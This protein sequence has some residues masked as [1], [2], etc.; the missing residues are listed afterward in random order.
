MDVWNKGQINGHRQAAARLETI[1]NAAFDFIRTRPDTTEYE[2]QQ[3]VKAEFRKHGLGRDRFYPNPIV[4][5]GPSSD[6]PHYMPSAKSSRRSRPNTLVM[7]DIWGHLPGMPFADITWMAFCGKK[8]PAEMKK[9]FDLVLRSR[10]AAIAHIKKELRAGRMP[11]GSETDR[12][13][14]DV[15]RKAGYGKFLRHSTGHALGTVS[16][17]H[18]IGAI[19]S[20]NRRPLSER[21]GYTIEPGIYL[22]R[23]FGIRSEMDFIILNRRF[24]PTTGMQK[25]LIRL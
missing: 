5:F 10:D 1:K 8:V 7:L 14:K 9:A 13:S 16:P 12:I 11:I 21:I 15:I 20:T 3:F 4:A 22:P 25:E 23:R 19:R 24:E 2:V 18:R 6:D 17:H